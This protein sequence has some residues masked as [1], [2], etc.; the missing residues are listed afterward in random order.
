MNIFVVD[1][2][3]TVAGTVLCDKHIVKMVLETA[4]LLSTAVH[5]YGGDAPYKPNHIN[6]PC[7]VWTRSSYDHFMW[8]CVH[9][10][11]IA[12]EYRARYGKRHKSHDAIQHCRK[13]GRWLMPRNGW[14]PQPMCMPDEYKTD[15]VV[16]SYRN[17]YIGDK[18]R[19]ATW[20]QNQPDWWRS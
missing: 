4:Q 19:F 20:K 2:D 11:A 1:A 9:G 3:P 17:Y 8:L 12:W 7:S 15:S 18:S 14:T 10:D 6:H 5:H 16:Q 13:V